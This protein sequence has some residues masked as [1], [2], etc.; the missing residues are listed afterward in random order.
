MDYAAS[1][2]KLLKMFDRYPFVEAVESREFHKWQHQVEVLQNG[3]VV[4]VVF[5]GVK[6]RARPL[7]PDYRVD[8]VKQGIQVPLSHANIIVD[9]YNK[10]VRRRELIGELRTLLGNIILE[11][12]IDP[13][14]NTRLLPEYESGVPPDALLLDEVEKVHRRLGKKFSRA[15]NQ[16]DL[17]VEELV[18]VIKWIALQE[19]IN[20]PMPRY[21][22]RRM[23]FARY[24]EAI[25]CAEAADRD[26]TEVIRRALVHRRRR[27]RRWRSVD[28]S[29]IDSVR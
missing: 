12:E 7:R 11:G 15:G 27:P 5:P 16:W 8:I 14:R 25:Y 10:C 23:P 6:A 1:R 24:L 17:T 3:S 19:D 26:L 18:A 4:R 9:I 20:Y 29:I 21:E 22:G 28:Y 2:K 13:Y